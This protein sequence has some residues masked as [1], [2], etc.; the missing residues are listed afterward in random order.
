MDFGEVPYEEIQEDLY[1]PLEISIGK[2]NRNMKLFWEIIMREEY[3]DLC[4]IQVAYLDSVNWD[5][6]GEVID[7]KLLSGLNDI[8]KT[9]KKEFM[10]YLQNPAI[11]WGSGMERKRK[12]M[13]NFRITEKEYLDS[14]GP[15]EPET[16]KFPNKHFCSEGRKHQII[17]IDGERTC[18]ECGLMVGRTR[19]VPEYGCC[20][21]AIMRSKPATIESK[22]YGFI[23]R[24][25]VSGYEL[26]GRGSSDVINRI[27]A[28][29]ESEKPKGKRLPNLNIISYQVCKRLGVEVNMSL[30]K[31]PMCK[32]PHNRCRKIF[33]T[34][35]WD[36]V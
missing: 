34:L 2:F 8:C 16:V 7:A 25:G 15:K 11:G 23:K 19:Y 18:R 32:A 1:T 35:G 14:L 36:Y 21:R 22:V 3:K 12:I 26:F 17:D 4:F 24:K 27:V 20:N 9:R 33:E 13:K 30:L 29:C 10:K 31:I 5:F 28:V 6:D